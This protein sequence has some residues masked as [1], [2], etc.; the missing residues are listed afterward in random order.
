MGTIDLSVTHSPQDTYARVRDRHPLLLDLLTT[1]RGPCRAGAALALVG[2][3]TLNVSHVQA[4]NECG[5]AQSGE[6]VVCSPSTYDPAG[7][8][9]FYSHDENGEDETSGDFT[10]RL[11]S[12]LSIDHD[13]ERPGADVYVSPEDD[14]ERNHG[15]VWI[16]PGEF[17]EY[18]GDVSLYSSADVTSNGLGIFAGHFG[19]SG[20]LRM[21]ILGGD[22]R[23]GSKGSHAISGYRHPGSDGELV[24]I[25]H[26]VTIGTMGDRAGGVSGWHK[27]VGELNIDA[28]NLTVTTEG[29]HA[30]GVL[31][32]RT[33]N[34][35]L[36]IDARKLDI[37]TSGAYARGVYGLHRGNGELNIDVGNL[38][39]TT[40]GD[41]AYGVIG[42]RQGD[43]EL[44]IDARNLT[45][46]T[47]GVHGYGVNG[48]HRGDG[49]LSIDAH[50]V[51]IQTAG[52]NGYGVVGLL[53]GDGELSIDARDLAIGTTGDLAN[54][55]LAWHRGDGNLNIDLRDV[56][57]TT[58]GTGAGGISGNHSSMDGDVTIRAR[59]GAV[60][61]SG[62][63][64]FGV[65]GFHSGAGTVDIDLRDTTVATTGTEADGVVILHRG[66]GPTRIAVY[67][68]SVHA[69]GSEAHGIRIGRL[70]EDGSLEPASP[71]D[72]DGYR[73]QSVSV[74]APVTGGS[75]ENAAGVFL[76][77]GGRVAI[78]RRGSIAAASRVAILASGGA[79]KLRVEINLDGRRVG[80]VVDGAI[81]N[82][83]GETTLAVNGI[84]LFEGAKGAKGAEAA[85]GAWDLTLSAS[86]TVQGRMFT[87]EDFIE[88]YAPR[89][90]VY[91]TLPGFLLRLND[92]SL[93]GE[94]IAWPDA[95]AWTR[96]SG[97]R[98][99]FE[100]I[101]ASVGATYGF[102]R[103]SAEAGLDLPLGGSVVGSF[104]LRHVSGTADVASPHGGGKIEAEGVGAA[105]GLSWSGADGYFARGRLALTNYKVDVSS[106]ARGSL[107]RDVGANGHDL[108]IEA[109]RRIAFGKDTA[110]ALRVSATRRSLS[111]GTF[112]D[113][114]GS[115]VSLTE[116]TRYAGGI[117]VTAE[118]TRS[119][120]DGELIL[121]VSSDIERALGGADT[122]SGVS[123]ERLY[124]E[125]TATRVLLG[126]GGIWRKGRL[127]L[128]ARLHAGTAGS[129]DTEYTGRVGFG[130]TF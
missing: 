87:A 41:Y 117:G 123:G 61:T 130:W 11:D 20:A 121:R 67:G 36:S 97:G 48:F 24:I 49:V 5:A 125:A 40:G 120:E 23:S 12:D 77:G 82:D 81:R 92:G 25:V 112:T 10:V 28:R 109:G 16:T 29:A 76:A 114:L 15:A 106:R 46:T 79:P 96:I 47:E 63:A 68:G 129:H 127:S 98:G 3:L 4:D 128:G 91:E 86:E 85:N 104:S 124:S 118:I 83:E 74:N 43:G 50:N 42:F 53:Q 38:S 34:G 54:A 22:I 44:N 27:G 51:D 9:I 35:K 84:T 105:A 73:K 45:V 89:A 60:S 21:E 19:K 107:A 111:G 94:R 31:G 59:H 30:H 7:G 55:V 78:G 2:T 13:G 8:N 72:A 33:G 32:W 64:A 80:D 6:E 26:G 90:A 122:A 116:T 119:L 115:R 14:E 39:V 65:R 88:T 37:E 95:R 58:T 100:P 56:S 62:E 113:A 70:R 17:G 69:S 1:G 93:S 101:S 71:V 66:T 102:R 108:G 18:T 99:S 126:L 110:L 75:G 52:V 103:I 57:A